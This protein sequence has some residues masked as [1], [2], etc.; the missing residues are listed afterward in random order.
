[1]ITTERPNDAGISL[2]EMLVVVSILGTVLG[3]VTQG[4]IVAQRTLNE[5]AG[6]LQG[7]SETNLSVE[8][9]TRV[10]RTA[11]L[12]SQIQA[13]C[14]GCD[15]AAFIAGDDRSV[16]FYA[17]ADND[18]ILPTSGTTDYGPRRVTY[19]V[20]NDGVLTETIQ[21]PN[22][23]A[24]NDFDYQYCV[25]GPSC[26]V[27]TRVLARDVLPGPIFTYYDRR[28]TV[29]ATPLESSASRLK[30]VD[31]ID[32]VLRIQPLERAE[33]STVTARV[34]LPNAD[35]LIQPTPTP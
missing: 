29:I 10:L 11:I 26:P 34:T 8:A 2:I 3:L 5:N 21:R 16:K 30:A 13:V 1:M 35:S 28:G 24:Y 31:S 18:G 27:R 20:S 6:R 22:V 25:P 23:H 7:V 9:M 19:S 12:P 32:L 33:S 14:A 4:M 17:N 15:V